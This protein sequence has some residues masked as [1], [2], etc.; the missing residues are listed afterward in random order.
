M[1]KQ[2]NSPLTNSQISE[3]IL[4]Q[5]YTNYFA[6]QQALSEMEETGLVTISTSHSTSMYHL[7][8]AGENT[9]EYFG[10]K[11]SDAIC[12]DIDLYLAEKKMEIINDLSTTS[13]YFPGNND[14]EYLVRCQVREH[15]STLIDLTL[16]VPSEKQAV[17]MCNRWKEK[18]QEI[19]AY[20]MKSLL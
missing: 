17:T 15:G 6:L 5:E 4:E 19:Y 9:L 2:V 1:L 18:S 12:Q 11:V 10:S 13:D 7:T 20:V 8:P 16:S 14:N 3:F